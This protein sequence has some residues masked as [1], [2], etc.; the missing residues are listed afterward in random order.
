MRREGD[1]TVQIVLVSRLKKHYNGRQTRNRAGEEQE[2]DGETMAKYQMLAEWIR[3]RI[4]EGVFVPGKRLPS[5][6]KLQEQ[7]C[8]SRQTVRKAL[9]VLEEE[10]VLKSRQGSGTYVVDKEAEER[11]KGRRIAVVTTYVDNY[12]FPGILRGIEHTLSEAGF[13]MQIAFTGNR[14]S[15]EAAVLKDLLS[16]ELRGLIIETTKSALPNPNLDLYRELKARGIPIVFINSR[17]PEL[18]DCPMV[19]LQDEMAGYAAVRHLIACGH[20]RI[21]GLFKSDDGQG[22]RRYQGFMRGLWEAGI[23]DREGSVAW[24]DTEDASDFSRMEQKLLE[25]FRACSGILCYNDSAS[26]EVLELLQQNG[27]RVPEDLS[28]VSVDDTELALLGNVGL[29]SVCHPKGRLGKEAARELLS[30]IRS[31]LPG[32]DHEFEA[33]LVERDSVKKL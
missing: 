26:R 8:V 10:G 14:L 9:S 23:Y 5:E 28:V 25:R 6:L 30:M 20:R 4:E 15:R 2:R 33:R 24:F 27:I 7:F 3:G 31:G 21:G 11:Q 22:I 13:Q 29:T 19:A 18:S 32:T 17:Y 12:I 16:Q 1:K